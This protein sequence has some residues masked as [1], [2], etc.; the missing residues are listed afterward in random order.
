MDTAPEHSLFPGW[1][2]AVE[3]QYET[4][5]ATLERSLEMQ[6]TVVDSWITAAE[7]TAPPETPQRAQLRRLEWG[8]NIWEETLLN[9]L[10]H[11]DD[12]I[13]EDGIDLRQLQMIWFHAMDDAFSEVMSRPM[14]VAEMNDTLE[15]VLTEQQQLNELRRDFLHASNLPTD[16][17]L[18]EVGERLL[19][20]EA[21]QK[22]IEEKLDMI[23]DAVNLEEA[24]QSEMVK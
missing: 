23:L 20:L 2:R 8:Y 1:G 21:R 3:W 15:D 17:D 6:R 22:K 9:T 24:I 4:A 5:R 7:S 16:R 12:A 11:L 10:V 19:N 18:E 13:R 14:F